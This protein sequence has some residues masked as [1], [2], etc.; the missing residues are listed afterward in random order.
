[1]IREINCEDKEMTTIHH[2]PYIA[3]D[4][5]IAEF[6]LKA[7]LLGIFFG[8]LFGVT[9]T[10]LA[11]KVGLTVSASIPIAVLTIALFKTFGSSTILENNIVQ[12]TGSAGESIAAGVAFTLPAL[13]FL[14]HGEDYF[15][16][17]QISTL[18]LCGGVI[19]VLFMIPLRRALIVEEH[20]RLPYPEGMACAD[21]LIAGEKGGSLAKKVFLGIGI[22]AIYKTLMSIFGFFKEIVSFNFSKQSYLPNAM[23]SCEISPELL[24]VGY[25]IGPKISSVMVSGSILASFVLTPAIAYFGQ[26]LSIAIFP[27]VKLISEMSTSE[28]WSNY[29]RYIGAGA[30]TFAG[31]ITLIKT[32]PTIFGS[33]FQTIRQFKNSS[34]ERE[35]SR[36]NQDLPLW[37]VLAGSAVIIITMAFIPSLPIN[38]LSSLLIVIA[39]FF[40]V[41]VTSRIVGIVGTSS[42]PVS[43][44]T[45]ATLMGTCLIF[46]SQGMSGDIYQP[47]ALIVGAIVAI[48]IANAG[49]TSQDLKTGF[50]IG[51]TPWKQQ[52]AIIIGAMT[53]AIAIG[54]TLYFLY[55]YIGIGEVTA[56][57]RTPLPAPQAMLMATIVKGFFSQS[58]PWTLVLLGMSIA[59]FI[60]LLGI[61]SLAFAIGL[62]LPMSTTMPIFVG[63]VVHWLVQQRKKFNK[64]ESEL[65]SGALFSSGLIAGGALMGILIAFL[66][67]ATAKLPDG[68]RASLMSFFN[69]GIGESMGLS[70]DLIAVAC[71]GLLCLFI[72]KSAFAKEEV[73]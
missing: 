38:L 12:T 70:G 6:T 46:L 22:A 45:I 39:G 2:K 32:L 66:I 13:T 51:A 35:E 41:T 31:F 23:L 25:I 33:M 59:L 3:S 64:E 67:G 4:Q 15:Q 62:Y 48:A 37:F 26:H 27:G 1:M 28:I 54:F 68:T 71:F 40:F 56:E 16:I 14:S 21:I 5:S 57:H 73:V 11:L 36:I 9:T 20:G 24:G 58:L 49:A 53:S 69:T 44:M 42:N 8:L 30:V 7:I 63:G 17:F 43:G 52:I 61:S 34:Q 47:T 50:L 19:G 72:Y 29:I 55:Q 65:E 60:E 10:Y 18:A